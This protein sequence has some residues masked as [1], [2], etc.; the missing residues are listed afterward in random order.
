M[1]GFMAILIAILFI[2]GAGIL[3]NSGNKEET[4]SG[5]KQEQLLTQQDL[6]NQ[7]QFLSFVPTEAPDYREVQLSRISPNSHCEYTISVLIDRNAYWYYRS[8][9]NHDGGHVED[10]LCF[11]NDQYNRRFLGRLSDLFWEKGWERGQSENEILLE[12]ISFVQ[13]IPYE[14]DI[15]ANGCADHWQYPLE[16]LYR[17]QGD[18]EDHSILLA[19]LLRELGYDIC[20]IEFSTHMAVGILDTGSFSGYYFEYQGNHYYYIETAYSY[21]DIGE[22]PDEYIEEEAEILV[23]D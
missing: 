4:R 5:Q 20:L 17:N 14:K 22:M 21:R 16:T 2:G 3:A 18:C 9:E 12:A 19:G 6:E 23:L 11:L 10:A 7:E 15:V 1:K 13:S 8:L